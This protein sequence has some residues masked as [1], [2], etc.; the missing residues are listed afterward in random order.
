LLRPTE[1][2]LERLEMKFS[3]MQASPLY[4]HFVLFR[5][6]Y[7]PQNSIP[8][9]GPRSFRNATAVPHTDINQRR[10][11]LL[12]IAALRGR[13]KGLC[14][15]CVQWRILYTYEITNKSTF[16]NMLKHML[17]FFTNMFRSL[18]WPSTGCFVKGIQL[19]DKATCFTLDFSV[20]F[21]V[22]IKCHN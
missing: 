4:Y 7:L 14:F 8:E 21:L 12:G 11:V 1:K 13:N 18:L 17:M 6:K 5:P 22:A 3:I 19:C 2:C 15:L 16:T 9:K 10:T 20:A